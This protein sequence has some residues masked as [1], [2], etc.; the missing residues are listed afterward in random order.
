MKG[1]F[2]IVENMEKVENQRLDNLCKKLEK[3]TKDQTIISAA[4]QYKKSQEIIDK[5]VKNENAAISYGIIKINKKV[6]ENIDKYTE[7]EKEY[8]EIMKKYENDLTELAQ[9]HDSQI[10]MGYIKILEEE[11]KQKKILAKLFYAK[12]EENLARERVDNSDDQ[13]SEKIYDMEEE[14]AKS[15]QKIRRTKTTIKKRILQKEDELTSLFETR[16]KGIQKE[17]IKGPKIFNKATRFFLG[18]LNPTK[19]IQRN[20]FNNLKKRI[21]EY[22]K[23]K[24]E[25]KIKDEYAEENIAKTLEKITTKD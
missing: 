10:V 13:I 18:K 2:S 1:L 24:I 15:E 17:S 5:K 8:Q 22:E 16:E 23:N 25:I 3:L 12:Q 14:I 19:Q 9:Y 7:V 20:V 6:I 21:D 4:I 11:L